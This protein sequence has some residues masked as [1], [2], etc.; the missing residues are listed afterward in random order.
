[1]KIDKKVMSDAKICM[2]AVV[3]LEDVLQII[4]AWQNGSFP[5]EDDSLAV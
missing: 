3:E 1:L 2:K 4:L 5:T